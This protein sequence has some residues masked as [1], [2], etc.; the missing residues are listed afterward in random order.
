MKKYIRVILILIFAGVAAFAGWQLYQQQA[1]YQSGED[2][3]AE[4]EQYVHISDPGVE[5]ELEEQEPTESGETEETEAEDDTVW[6]TVDFAA[7]Q[8]INPDV[9]AWI[10]IEGTSINYPIVQGDDNSYYL[11]HLVDGSYNSS[12]AIF[13]DYRNDSDFSDSHTIIYGHH[14]KNGTMFSGLDGYKKQEFYEE[15]P[16]ALV[17]TPEGNFKLEFFA[18]YVADVEADA[19]QLNFTLESLQQWISTAKMKSCFDN[20]IAPTVTDQ[21]VTL[22]TCSYEFTNARF[23]L[24]G[25][26]QWIY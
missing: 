20:N 5:D 6:P 8:T 15:H 3:Y 2:T 4:L 23:V 16:T 12:G 7:L 1:E 18:G 19:W 22:S 24:L 17:L 26:I 13:M 21:I 9:V 10:Y 11:K 25:R 14:M